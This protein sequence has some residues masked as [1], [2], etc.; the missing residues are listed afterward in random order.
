MSRW[1]SSR[2]IRDLIAVVGRESQKQFISTLFTRLQ[3]KKER[4]QRVGH[5]QRLVSVPP[6]DFES[7]SQFSKSPAAAAENQGSIR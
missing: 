1:T 7:L 5:L 3:A 2:T 6:G 4:R